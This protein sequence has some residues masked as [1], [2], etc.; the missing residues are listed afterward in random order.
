MVR[1]DP[2]TLSYCLRIVSCRKLLECSANLLSWNAIFLYTKWFVFSVEKH[3]TTDLRPRN[4]FVHR[5]LFHF[6][7]LII[8]SQ[9]KSDLSGETEPLTLALHFLKAAWYSHHLQLPGFWGWLVRAAFILSD[10]MLISFRI[11]H[12]S[13]FGKFTSCLGTE[14]VINKPVGWNLIIQ[15]IWLRKLHLGVYVDTYTNTTLYSI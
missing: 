9:R 8:H 11:L 1:R 13:P 5:E 4:I 3:W 7:L 10:S 15:A 2:T 6:F 14:N 12:F